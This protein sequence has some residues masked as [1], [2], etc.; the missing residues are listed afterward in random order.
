MEPDFYLPDRRALAGY[1]EKDW[2]D[3][4]L[5]Q[6]GLPA[7]L[8]EFAPF[9]PSLL[10]SDGHERVADVLGRTLM[11]LGV[12]PERL[13]EVGSALGRGFYEICRRM[14]SVRS[15]TLVEPSRALAATFES[16]F[17]GSGRAQ[18][19]MLRGNTDIVDVVFDSTHLQ[20][21]VQGVDV[22]LVN[23]SHEELGADLGAFDLVACFGVL[24]QCHSPRLLVERLKAHTAAGGILALSCGYQWS[25]KHLGPNETPIRNINDLFTDDW[26]PL[27]E[28]NIE[29]TLRKS[30]RHW[31]MFVSQVSVFQK[32]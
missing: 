16:L 8:F 14:P 1:F 26:T 17:R 21:V 11:D 20:A 7:S 24:D 4:V 10:Y 18:Y 23:S 5:E 28:T 22:S 32:R 15:A 19:P 29:F 31:W 13:L 6:G 30:E 25:K 12:A 2:F 9:D 27:S 3:H